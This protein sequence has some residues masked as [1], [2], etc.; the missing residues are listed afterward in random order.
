M[1]KEIKDWTPSCPL[2][3]SAQPIDQIAKLSGHMGLGSTQSVEVVQLH[4]LGLN[5]PLDWIAQLSDHKVLTS[6]QPNPTPSNLH[7]RH[8]AHLGPRYG[9]TR[10]PSENPNTAPAGN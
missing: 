6:T 5:Q 7:D 10:E 1:I 9:S 8:K 3:A 4:G 2:Q